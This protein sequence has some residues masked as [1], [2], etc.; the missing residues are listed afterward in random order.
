MDAV[1]PVVCGTFAVATMVVLEVCFVEAFL[2]EA[3]FCDDFRKIT[4]YQDS[5]SVLKHHG[6]EPLFIKATCLVFLNV[7]DPSSST[8]C[9][10]RKS[11]SEFPGLERRRSPTPTHN[12]NNK[13]QR[14]NH[15]PNMG[16]GS[17]EMIVGV[18]RND[19]RAHPPAFLRVRILT[20]NK[21]R[22]AIA[23]CGHGKAPPSD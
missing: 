5:S 18:S 15:V 23:V 1:Y 9:V 16:E 11:G 20:R 8:D 14:R 10:A 12:G 7:C 4:P 2:I 21:F 6:L 22:Q 19:G 3:N 13:R 17:K